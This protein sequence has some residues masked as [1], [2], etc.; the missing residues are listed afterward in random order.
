MGFVRLLMIAMGALIL[1]PASAE[2]ANRQEHAARIRQ[3]IQDSGVRP[4]EAINR[5]LS[6][7]SDRE[8]GQLAGEHAKIGSVSE[9]L[10]VIA[11][12]IGTLFLLVTLLV[13]KIE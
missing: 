3:A 2:S 10:M 5:K 9:P 6:T 1:A 4:N 13:K 11:G 12:A 8:L 7:M